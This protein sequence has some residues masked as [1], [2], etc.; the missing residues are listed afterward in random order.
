MEATFLMRT[1]LLH[2]RKACRLC[3]KFHH[4]VKEAAQGLQHLGN[5]GSE[6]REERGKF[7]FPLTPHVHCASILCSSCI[8]P[9]IHQ[10]VYPIVTPCKV[11]LASFLF[12]SLSF[13]PY[14]TTKRTRLTP[15]NCA[16]LVSPT[17]LLIS[18]LT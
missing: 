3:L 16:V 11:C 9:C 15:T 5:W 7:L 10:S 4:S 12:F 2:Q 1:L 6:E 13:H 14:Q 18:T 8:H 17:L